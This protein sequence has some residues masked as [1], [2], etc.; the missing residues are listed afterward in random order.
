MADLKRGRICLGCDRAIS[1][2][3]KF[4]IFKDGLRHRNCDNP[5]GYI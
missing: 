4:T 2:H 5:E 1:L 3:D